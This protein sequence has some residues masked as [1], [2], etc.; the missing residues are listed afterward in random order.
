MCNE[1]Y[2]GLAKA[3]EAELKRRLA[4]AMKNDKSHTEVLSQ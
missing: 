1:V 4:K 2:R 3:R